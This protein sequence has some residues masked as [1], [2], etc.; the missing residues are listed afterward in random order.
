MS[1]PQE[2]LN[3]PVIRE[4]QAA[5]QGVVASRPPVSGTLFNRGLVSLRTNVMYRYMNAEGLPSGIRRIDSDIQTITPSVSLD[6]GR[7]W[8]VSYIPSWNYYSAPEFDDTFDQSFSLHGGLIGMHW[9]LTLDQNLSIA[10]PTLYETGRQTEQ[11]TWSTNVAASRS[12]GS[13]YN[14]ELN[15]RVSGLQSEIGNDSREWS[16][17]DWF[18]VQISP[19]LS[20]GVG[21]TFGY[22]DIADAPDMT[23]QRFMG[24]LSFSPTNKL[25]LTA[26]GGVERRQTKSSLSHDIENPILS[27]SAAYR[28]FETTSITASFDHTVS[29]A[30]YDSQVTVGAYWRLHF[31]Q[32][33]LGR[34]YFSADWSHG[35][36]EYKST[37]VVTVP[38]APMDTD[39]PSL[40][41][42]V[43]SLPGRK[44]KIEEFNCRLTTKLFKR[45]SIAAT[46]QQTDNQS[47]Q[48]LYDI[49]SK[50][51]GIE[52]N[53]SF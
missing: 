36:N 45:M 47:S 3:A 16:T 2:A 44:D 23:Y 27:V 52:I 53:C 50:Q 35:E 11:K 13:R 25:S 46:Y 34:L 20:A 41:P 22:V 33:L 26:S 24:R 14:L 42:V 17:D 28:P 51:Y 43:V 48:G 9:L 10:S 5:Q 39:D 4:A 31:E 7:H 12:I 15:G 1:L 19:A 49:S 21:P 40:P 30:L 6:V 32:R 29:T 8:S 37:S 38:P 18:M